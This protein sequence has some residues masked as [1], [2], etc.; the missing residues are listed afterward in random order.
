MIGIRLW[1]IENEVPSGYSG[2]GGQML[3]QAGRHN[4]HASMP[5]P[6]GGAGLPGHQVQLTVMQTYR[7]TMQSVLRASGCVPPSPSSRFLNDLS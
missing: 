3:S 6:L 2:Q 1:R 7:I 4:K 5:L